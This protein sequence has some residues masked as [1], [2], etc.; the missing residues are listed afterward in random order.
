MLLKKKDRG[1][2]KMR[3][4]SG[5][6]LLIVA[7]V[8][9]ILVG[10]GGSGKTEKK[11][12]SGDK[13]Q[14]NVGV[15][16]TK[17]KL[18]GN[19]FNDV[20][21]SG[22]KRAE[23]SLGITFNEVEPDTSSDQENA[24]ETMA[25]TGDYDLIIAVGQE[26]SDIVDKIAGKYPD[27]KFVMIDADLEKDN[28]AS[29]ILKEEEG[30]FIVG[31]LVAL[32]AEAQVSEKITDQH[33]FGFVGGVNNPQINK[34]LAGYQAGIQYVNKDNKVIADYVG[35][36]QDPSTAKV[37]TNTMA[38]KGA[39]IIYHAAGAS[40]SGVFQAAKEQDI[41]AVGCNTNQ[42]SIEPETIMASMLKKADESV[43][44]S[45]EDVVNGN[46]E[47]GVHYLGL[48]EDAVGYTLDGSLIEVPEEVI[49]DVEA[50]REQAINGDF[51]I[52][53]SIDDVATFVAENSYKK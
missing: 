44:R 8:S 49:A 12:Q 22:L 11:S 34:F 6:L 29:Y 27:Q 33:T 7:M 45:I 42:N 2:I 43:L 30:S 32:A 46:F 35:G 38:Q 4:K 37:M 31:A 14:V 40:G 17:A 28:V 47:A 9:L 41:L 5:V 21:Q 3:K 52:P 18:G 48:K 20:V 23:D 50:I 25:S 53:E 13:S 19:S 1:E 51:V 26:Q 36:F 10:C 15:I 39:S 16:Y 24:Q